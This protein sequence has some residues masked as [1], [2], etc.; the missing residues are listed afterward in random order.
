[1]VRVHT[2]RDQEREGD[3]DVARVWEGG[4]VTN[5]GQVPVENVF[6][7]VAGQVYLTR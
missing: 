4:L 7:P 6:V 1:M 2:G 3:Q 5:L